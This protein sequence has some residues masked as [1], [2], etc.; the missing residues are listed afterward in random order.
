MAKVLLDTKCLGAQ[1]AH[2]APQWDSMARLVLGLT[3][4][5]VASLAHGLMG[6][7]DLGSTGHSQVL[8]DAARAVVVAAG[9]VADVECLLQATLEGPARITSGLRLATQ[10]TLVLPRRGSMGQCLLEDA[11]A[12]EIAGLKVN[13]GHVDATM[14]GDATALRLA[15]G[16]AHVHET[17]P[18]VVMEKASAI[19]DVKLDQVAAPAID[20]D[21]LAEPMDEDLQS[22]N[23]TPSTPAKLDRKRSDESITGKDAKE[24]DKKSSRDDKKSSRDD[25]KTSRDD[26]KTSQSSRRRAEDSSSSSRAKDRSSGGDRGRDRDRERDRERA[27]DKDRPR[28]REKTNERERD[29]KE[30]DRPR[31]RKEREGKRARDAAGDD[32][33]AGGD[34]KR[35]RSAEKERERRGE[36]GSNGNGSGRVVTTASGSSRGSR[37]GRRRRGGGGG[38][39]G[40]DDKRRI[41]VEGDGK[42]GGND[43][44]RPP[45]KKSDDRGGKEPAA[46][47]R[48]V[49]DRLGPKL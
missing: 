35:R 9:A 13:E 8:A 25:K 22:D 43:R 36:K 20:L 3:G 33:T 29:R 49:L 39:G 10:T 5:P 46:K 28:D 15:I 30:R 17:A 2:V 4:L 42:S 12:V 23:E 37:G 14:T 21:F 24:E 18:L 40:D 19:V 32:A 38:G 7:L 27:R 44:K 16:I 41:E 26:K 48:S 1:T 11:E 31:D 47:K 6:R 45:R 34:R